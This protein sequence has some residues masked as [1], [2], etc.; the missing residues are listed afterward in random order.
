MTCPWHIRVTSRAINGFHRH[1]LVCDLLLDMKK[2]EVVS[3]LRR[4]ERS[5]LIRHCELLGNYKATLNLHEGDSPWTQSSSVH[6]YVGSLPRDAE[7][8]A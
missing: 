3:S 7:G 6:F 2:K 1:V 4:S 5:R 8:Q